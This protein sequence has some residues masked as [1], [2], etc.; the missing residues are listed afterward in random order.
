[1]TVA[2]AIGAA[3][4]LPDF[5]I[6]TRWLSSQEKDLATWRLLADIGEEDWVSSEQQTI[7]LG[8][9]QCARDY[10]S[11][12]LV[13][14]VFGAVS[15]GTI[16]SYFP[17]VVGTLGYGEV[18]TLLL[19]APPYLLSCIVSIVVSWNAD[20]TGERYLH[21]TLPL[22]TSVAGFIISASVT[23][24]AARYFSIMIMLPGVYTAFTIGLVWAANTL[25]RPPAKRAALLALCNACGNCSSIYGPFLYPQSTAP[26]YLIAMCINA[27]TALLSIFTATVLRFILKALNKRMDEGD[28]SREEAG[29]EVINREAFRFLY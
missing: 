8:L 21:F 29:E 11:W 15:S 25:P 5:P 4:V 1:M 3:F 23:N 18:Q 9:S 19:T 24:L 17:T 7:F 14:L 22:W 6:N 26:R 10:K 2:I 12:I 27:G 28:I 16:S 13:A 20:R